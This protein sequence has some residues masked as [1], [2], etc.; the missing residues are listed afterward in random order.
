M[1]WQKYI[2]ADPQIYH[3]H[4]CIAGTRIM[5]SVVL[6]NLAAGLGPEDI[7]S[8]CPSLIQEDIRACHRICC[9]TGARSSAIVARVCK[10]HCK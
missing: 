7:M 9:G 5:V 10:V 8:S 1:D 2:S 3:G 6:D 4:A